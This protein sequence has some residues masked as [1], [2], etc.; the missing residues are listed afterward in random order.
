MNNT[1]YSKS[2]QNK[3]TKQNKIFFLPISMGLNSGWKVWNKWKIV[4]GDHSVS[5]NKNKNRNREINK[6]EIRINAIEK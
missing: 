4:G 1:L 6:N 3:Y 5:K 2:A